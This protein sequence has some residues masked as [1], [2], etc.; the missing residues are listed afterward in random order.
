MITF[1]KCRLLPTPTSHNIVMSTHLNT[2]EIALLDRLRAPV[3]SGSVLPRHAPQNK[4]IW[5][6]AEKHEW[7][8]V[9]TY[10]PFY[11]YWKDKSHASEI[12]HEFPYALSLGV[13]GINAI[14][15]LPAEN[16]ASSPHIL[17]TR[18]YDDMFHRLLR[19]R[20]YE[21]GLTG[22]VIVGQPGIGVPP[23]CHTIPCNRSLTSVQGKL[24][25]SY[26]CSSSCC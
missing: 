25:S 20:R 5:P 22:A 15:F 7:T 9:E 12:L 26:I 17:V 4:W 18:A 6:K 10:K 13:E 8:E 1:G 14:P 21:T 11:K 23:S 19:L 24:S 3:H 16:Q 2:D